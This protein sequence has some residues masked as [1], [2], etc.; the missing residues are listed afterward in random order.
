MESWCDRKWGNGYEFSIATLGSKR[1]DSFRSGGVDVILD[2]AVV[3]YIPKTAWR[4]AYVNVVVLETGVPN[5]S[6]SAND[7]GRSPFST[8]SK[9]SYC[10]R[11]RFPYLVTLIAIAPSPRMLHYSESIER[12][13]IPMRTHRVHRQSETTVRRTSDNETGREM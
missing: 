2:L 11:L 12:P 8:Q 3:A 6:H 1:Y 4:D 10:L 13:K 5:A 7:V 9:Y